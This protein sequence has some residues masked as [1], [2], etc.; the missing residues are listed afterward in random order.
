ML[1]QIGEC[2]HTGN[3]IMNEGNV[4]LFI[5]DKGVYRSVDGVKISFLLDRDEHF[6]E[7]AGIKL[8][9]SPEK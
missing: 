2:R 3:E 9:Q 1:Y 5:S 4:L 8:S 6:P 7:P